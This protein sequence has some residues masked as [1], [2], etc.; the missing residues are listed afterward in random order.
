MLDW[1]AGEPD[2]LGCAGIR[3]S[4]PQH[5]RQPVASPLKEVEGRMLSLFSV[6][7]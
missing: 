2:G 7:I 3:R 1:N 6:T 5:R 4:I